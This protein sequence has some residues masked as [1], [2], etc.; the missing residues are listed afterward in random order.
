MG[1]TNMMWSSAVSEETI[2]REAFL[3]C[4]M[5]IKRDLGEY[6]PDL[7]IAFVSPHH[8]EDYRSLTELTSSHFAESLLFGCSG[9][10]VIGDGR[11]IEQR[12]GLALT[13]AVLP[14][15]ELVP[16]YIEDGLL[17]DGDDPPERWADM[18]HVPQRSDVD[19]VILA[20]PFTVNSEQLLMGLDYAFPYASKI[21]GLVSGGMQP[22]SH[23]LYLGDQIHESGLIGFSMNGN[24]AIDIVVA[25]GCRPI[26]EPMY[27]TACRGNIL[28][29]LDNASPLEMLKEIFASLS[30]ADRELA[31]K[32][33]F[34]GVLMDELNDAPRQGDFLIRN[35]VGIDGQ[36]G[37]IAVGDNLKE[38]QTVQFHL[39]DAQ[40]SSLDL[41][42]MLRQYVS[43]Q[44]SDLLLEGSRGAL[45]FQCLG[46]GSYLYG[47]PDHDTDAFKDIVGHDIPLTGFFCNGEIGPVGES[48]FLHG[49]T[50][51][52]G[53][54]RPKYKDSG[55]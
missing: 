3:E 28:Q 39:R 53:V 33:L 47:R 1:N 19:F 51:S 36:Q 12:P 8:S 2:L 23:V 26:G 29:E 20:D 21:G 37:A 4:A 31:Q 42:T 34:I 14:D 18:V 41:T 24:V 25:Q 13:A 40:T 46:R 16:F 52:V 7:L 9:G 43:L 5:K 45:M 50:T 27:V 55:S 17:P 6:E 54:V 15:V 49:Y 11:E 44:K 22:G 30:E 48:T 10:G 35:I 32:S 38:G